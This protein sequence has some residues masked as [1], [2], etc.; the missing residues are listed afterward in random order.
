MS[1]HHL[2]AILFSLGILG[3]YPFLVGGGV[4][5]YS[6]RWSFLGGIEYVAFGLATQWCCIRYREKLPKPIALQ[7]LGGGYLFVPFLVGS[8]YMS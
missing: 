8:F 2:L 4:V 5:Y 6:P 1:R 7:L 3:W